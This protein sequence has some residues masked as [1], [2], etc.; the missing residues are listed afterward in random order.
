MHRGQEHR[1]GISLH[2]SFAVFAILLSCKQKIGCSC[3]LKLSFSGGN[4]IKGPTGG[5]NGD[6]LKVEG[7]VV[8]ASGAH[9]LPWL[10]QKEAANDNA[11]CYGMP[12]LD[13]HCCICLQ[14]IHCVFD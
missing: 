9:M 6:V 12:Q 8:I 2:H 11:V 13:R 7:V 3:C 4:C 1:G 10:K 5:D 14:C